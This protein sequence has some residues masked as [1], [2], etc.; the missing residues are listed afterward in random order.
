MV[1][2]LSHLNEIGIGA[3]KKYVVEVVISYSNMVEGRLP[4]CEAKILTMS[5]SISINMSLL[6]GVT[7]HFANG[8]ENVLFNVK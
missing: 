7:A 6:V 4:N 5:E 3:L 1:N 8:G 2:Y